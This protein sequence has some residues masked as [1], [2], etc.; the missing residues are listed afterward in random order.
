MSDKINKILS[1]GIF[2]F[3]S[4]WFWIMLSP[5]F[6]HFHETTLFFPYTWTHLKEA[7]CVPGGPARYIAE[8]FVQFFLFKVPAGIIVTASFLFLQVLSWK[9]FRIFKEQESMAL[10]AMS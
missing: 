3:I 10:Y 6:L 2:V 9:L 7:L 1:F 4:L 8:F 5:Y